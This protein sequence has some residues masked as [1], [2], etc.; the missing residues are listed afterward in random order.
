MKRNLVTQLLLWKESS[1]RKPLLLDG[2]RQVGKSHLIE[3]E[4]GKAFFNKTHKFDFRENP[5]LKEIFKE[6]LLPKKILRSLE[7]EIGQKI[8]P[9]Q[10]LIFFDEIGEC[11]EAV[12]SLKYFA[13]KCSDFF[14][15]ASGSNIGLL[16]S[17]PV[18]K[19]YNLELFPMSF[20]EF[21]L[22]SENQLLIEE[23]EAQSTLKKTHEKLWEFFLHYYFVG[24]M[25]EAVSAWFQGDHLIDKIKNVS[26][27]HADLF[28]GYSRDFG[29]FGGK[30]NALHIESV[31]K[32][33]P[34][35]LQETHDDS[36]KRF[37]FKNII[38]NKSRYIDLRGPIDWL[39]KSKLI[40]KNHIITSAPSIPLGANIKENIFK[41][42]F[43]DVG[44]MCHSLGLTYQDIQNQ[45]F[46]FK[47]FIAENFVQNELRA[48]GIYPIYSWQE[49]DAEIEFLLKIKNGE[50]IP[51][52]V[53]SGKR[54]KAKSL[55]VYVEKY[56]PT[57]A[58]KL[59][60]SVGA[61]DKNK[62]VWPLYYAGFADQL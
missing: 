5:R 33:I 42:F 25:P 39:E 13:E 22:A 55:K 62:Y 19:T 24:G 54:T 51:L 31:F 32:Q 2:A 58:L 34:I 8:D 47:G 52:E 50:I 12:D 1:P 44:L 16:N 20:Y 46:S 43:F 7:L 59:V 48:K 14:I 6:S 15:C 60:G 28:V 10:D 41:L 3:V 11:Q 36:V 45:E 9:Q 61:G 37:Q 4:F 35:R 23:Y 17:F 18:G 40:S 27:I 30:I 57:I 49:G 21:L 26:K 38:E 53:K 29:K 56:N